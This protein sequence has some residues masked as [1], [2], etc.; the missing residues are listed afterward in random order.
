MSV[1][2][3]QPKGMTAMDGYLKPRTKEEEIDLAWQEH[4]G[5]RINRPLPF[6]PLTRDR[7]AGEQNW[8]CCWAFW[9]CRHEMVPKQGLP[10]SATFEHIIPL[11]LGG[12][13]DVENVAISCFSCNQR[14]GH[15]LKRFRPKTA[16]DPAQ[17]G[18]R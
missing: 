1:A 11:K 16:P 14:R 4:E 7:L 13:Y 15:S 10:H 9:G 17:G 2:S 8:R 12:T 18:A 3:P 5:P 6:T